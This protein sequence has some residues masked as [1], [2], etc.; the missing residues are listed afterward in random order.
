[1]NSLLESQRGRNA[2]WPYIGPF[3]AFV[4]LLAITPYLPFGHEVSYPLRVVLVS[5][6]LLVCS[7][8]LVRLDASRWLSS[9]AVG[10]LVF[11][12]WI[13]PDLIWPGYRSHWLL[14]N[15]LTGAAS[16]SLPQDAAQNVCIWFGAWRVRCCWSRS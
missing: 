2:S 4:V 7:R 3:L 10:V 13:G 5:A 12:I 14:Q 15:P 16:S 1:L 9:V 8:K 11:L 6:V